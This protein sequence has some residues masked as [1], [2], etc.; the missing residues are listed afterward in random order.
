MDTLSRLST[1][2]RWGL[3]LAAIA[4]ILVI[5]AIEVRPLLDPHPIRLAT[6]DTSCDLSA[7]PC[8]ARFTTGG[9]VTL[10]LEPRG[11]PPLKTLRLAVST[12]GIDAYSVQ[13]DFAGADMDMGFNR[14]SLTPVG[15]G[16][17][18]GEGMLPIC[19]SDRMAW[20]ARVLLETPDGLLAAPFR[21]ETARSR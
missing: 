17:Y 3:G 18:Q 5:A 9:S 10:D 1:R 15:P 19:V 6:L 4:A 8:T 11:I 16:R 14:P 20:E 12:Q 21:F 7:G 13:V 2:D